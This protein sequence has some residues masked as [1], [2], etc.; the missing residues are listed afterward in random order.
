MCKDKC[1]NDELL[2]SFIIIKDAK[3]R[4]LNVS[5]YKHIAKFTIIRDHVKKCEGCGGKCEKIINKKQEEESMK[6]EK[7]REFVNFKKALCS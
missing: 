5:T 7:L 4:G 3:K 2:R 1:P 6:K